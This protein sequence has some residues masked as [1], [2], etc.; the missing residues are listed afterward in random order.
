MRDA[1][2]RVAL[3]GGSLVMRGPKKRRYGT[4]ERWC[5][6]SQA[7]RL[8]PLALLGITLP[9]LCPTFVLAQ[10]P[11][12]K[13]LQKNGNLKAML[14][15]RDVQVGTTGYQGTRWTVRPSGAWD[16]RQVVGRITRKPDRTGKLTVRQLQQ[17]ADVLAH[18]QV[19]D[20]P[21][22]LGTYRGKT[23]HRVTLGW[24]KQQ[25]VWSLP[26]GTPVPRYPD[27]PFGKLTREDCFAEVNQVLAHLLQPPRK[28]NKKN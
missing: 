27:Q 14:I 12:Q 8:W 15:L 11:R 18:A 10:L 16:R 1:Q 24:G 23:P 4:T 21:V 25:C 3:F 6:Q 13:Y 28:K 17:L 5:R 26:P 20:L 7:R 22:R 2:E 9:M 19:K